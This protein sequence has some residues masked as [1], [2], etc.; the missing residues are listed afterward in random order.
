[1]SARNSTATARCRPGRWIH[2]F[3]DHSITVVDQRRR[4]AIEP[5]GGP[6]EPR[7]RRSAVSFDLATGVRLRD[8]P[9]VRCRFRAAEA[10]LVEWTFPNES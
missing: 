6:S 5:I 2:L 7:V 9:D 4:R 1:M 10:M 3:I 8:R